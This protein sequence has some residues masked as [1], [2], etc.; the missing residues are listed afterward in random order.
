MSKF[1]NG[2]SVLF[3]AGDRVGV[4]VAEDKYN[5]GHCIYSGGDYFYCQ[6]GDFRHQPKEQKR[7]IATFPWFGNDCYVTP[8][9]FES[10][11]ELDRYV[12]LVY[13]ARDYQAIEIEVEV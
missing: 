3:G 11:E 1:K 5:D 10:A 12:L 8:E 9:H 13:G 4:Y 7:W 6:S 2:D